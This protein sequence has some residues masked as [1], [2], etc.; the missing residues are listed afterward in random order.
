MSQSQSIETA[1]DFVHLYS[2]PIASLQVELQAY[3]HQ[4]TGATHLH[5]HN[6][7]DDHNVFLVG[8]R[9]VP[10]DSTGVAHILEH[11]SLCGSERFPVRDPFFAMIRRSLNTF[12]NAFTASDWTAYPFASRN[13]KDFDNL[14]QVYLDATFFPNLDPLDFAQEG[15]RIEFCEPENP[16]SPLCYKGVVYNEMK[17]ALSS[18]ISVLW[19]EL[20]SAIFPTITYHHNSGGDPVNIPDLTYQQLKA[21]HARHYHPSNALFMTYGD[22]PAAHHQARFVELALHRFE[23]SEVAFSI[24][25]E[26]RYTTPQVVERSYALESDQHDHQS[27]IVLGW[28]LGRSIDQREVLRAHLLSGVLLDNSASPLRQWLETCGIGSAPSPISGL[29]DSSRE[30]LFS[31]GIEGGDPEQAEP[32]E[33]ALL[34]E[35]TRIADSGVELAM[36]EA[37]LHQLELQQREIGGD[38][39][40][41]G[42]QLL[43]NALG[44]VLHG[45]DPV[46]VIDIDPLLAEL[47]EAIQDR[48]FIP[49][50]IRQLLLDNPHR[51]R[52]TLRPDPQLATAREAAEAARLAAIATDLDEP[53]REAI[54]EQAAALAARQAQEDDPDQL[55]RVGL[56]DIPADLTIP[57]GEDSTLANMP[58]RWYA[59][60]TNGIVYQEVLLDLPPLPP[61]L[62]ATL[63]LFCDLVTEVGS[64][65]RD[66]LATQ[67]LQAAVSGGVRV[68]AGVRTALDNTDQS[69]GLLLFSGKALQRNS[70]ALAQLLYESFTAPRFD[71]LNR[72]RELV[73]QERL[74]QEQAVTQSGHLLAMTAA[75]AGFTP[76]AALDHQWH[77]LAAIQQ[78]KTLDQQLADPAQLQAFADRLSAIAAQLQQAPRQLLLIG[79]A[80]QQRAIFDGV[81]A[82]WGE[83]AVATDDGSRFAPPA[84]DAPVAQRQ[85]WTTS[86]QVSFC[87]RAYHCVPAAHP[88]AA[89]L[90]VLGGFL[91][92]NFLHRTIREQ[93]GAYGGGAGYDG[94]NGIFRFYSYRD[95]RLAETLADF[96]RA[97]DWL[98]SGHHSWRL[99][100]EAILGVISAIDKPGSP[101]GEAK[102]A[103]H[104]ELYGRTPA[105]RRAI[106]QQVLGVREADLKRVA[107]RYLQPE[108]ASTA[109]VSSTAIAAKQPAL[110]LEPIAL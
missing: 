74:H 106:R 82:T 81:A 34:A 103:F 75:A 57:E 84:L 12:M 36:V 2:R 44:P 88:D 105:Q 41:F 102:Q 110:D 10:Q 46:A 94:D 65:G 93:G 16:D 72:L 83:L 35:L 68:H 63:P 104:S 39:F 25:D 60:G 54:R 98:L 21:F 45:A 5:L 61:P 108:R 3:R 52:L 1:T 38:G 77:G 15:H 80:A 107:E 17:G 24:P 51:V 69:R 8:F 86:T 13:R 50:L 70:T 90:R 89:A 97:I 53:A 4:P 27:H 23:Q 64:G 101:A 49:Q 109:V 37:V 71:E 28:L 32:F 58:T 19:Q 26:Q 96:D 66:Y 43:V 9:T 59:R 55:P 7:S 56:E 85:L 30:M 62:A 42:L 33:Q 6:A 100:E 40:P 87:A 79:E 14:L 78:L 47:R 95:P 99:V 29:S 22:I 92:N 67:S 91:R 76:V 31:C 73:T 20:T 18:P 48:D 11:T